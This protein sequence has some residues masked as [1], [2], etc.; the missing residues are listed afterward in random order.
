MTQPGNIFER[1]TCSNLVSGG[2]IFLDSRVTENEAGKM[3]SDPAAENQNQPGKVCATNKVHG[4]AH[5]LLDCGH[6]ARHVCVW[7]N[8]TAVLRRS[9]SYMISTTK[10]ILLWQR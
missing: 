6:T 2:V 5:S 3:Q 10:V 4:Y 7:R 9:G 1:N 8:Q